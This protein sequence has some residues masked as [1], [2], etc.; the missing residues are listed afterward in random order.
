MLLVFVL[1]QVL[2]YLLDV[3]NILDSVVFIFLASTSYTALVISHLVSLIFC[4][5]GLLMVV[6]HLLE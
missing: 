6:E 2:E 1:N 5:L 4:E 3:V